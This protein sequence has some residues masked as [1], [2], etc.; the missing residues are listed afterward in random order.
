MRIPVQQ[1]QSVLK[2]TGRDFECCI[3]GIAPLRLGEFGGSLLVKCMSSQRPGDYQDILV[4]IAL[5]LTERKA[6][7]Q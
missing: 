1:A 6:A 4:E 5:R 7:T 3:C 2:K